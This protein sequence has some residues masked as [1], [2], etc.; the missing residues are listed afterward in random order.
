[1]A[2]Q[3]ELREYRAAI[4]LL[5]EQWS[6]DPDMDACACMGPS[7]G[8]KLCPCEERQVTVQYMRNALNFLPT[9]SGH[10]Q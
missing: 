3:N 5:L 7:E 9:F 1:M 2:N 10:P 8:H 4:E 6:T